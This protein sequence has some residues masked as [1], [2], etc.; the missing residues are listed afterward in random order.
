MKEIRLAGDLLGVPLLKMASQSG[1]EAIRAFYDEGLRS[2][3]SASKESASGVATRVAQSGSQ[4]DPIDLVI[5]GGG[6]AG[7][8]A[9]LEAKKLNLNFA[10]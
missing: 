4:S 6:V 8:S 3:T 9:A 2:V 7:I 10:A 5:V 1:A